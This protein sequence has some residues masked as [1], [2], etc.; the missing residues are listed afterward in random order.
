MIT[1]AVL[2]GGKSIR[3]G[4]NKALQEFRGKRFVELAVESLAPFCGSVM[5]VVNDLGPYRDLG[6]T[7]VRD[8]IPHQG[9]LGGIYT[10]LLF[11]SCDWVLVKATDMPFLVPDLASL[12]IGAK[13]GYDAVVPKLGEYYEPLLA[14]YHRRCLPPIARQLET[15]GERQ[16]VKFFRKIRIRSVPEEEWRKVDPEGFSFRNV[17][18]QSDL[19]EIDGFEKS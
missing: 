10:A 15:P 6:V 7:L 2:A 4:K 18:T 13:S 17:N 14:L 1:G 11:S 5:V 9:P 12:I 3:F 8:L 16:I 19:A